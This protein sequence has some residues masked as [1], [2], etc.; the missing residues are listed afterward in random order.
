[1]IFPAEKME[2]VYAALEAAREEISSRVLKRRSTSED[3]GAITISS[4][5]AMFRR[6]EG[7]QALVERADAAM[8]ASKRGGRNKTTLAEAVLTDVHAA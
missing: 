4:G 3:L 7:P 6:G 1:M 8:Y 5:I 2:M